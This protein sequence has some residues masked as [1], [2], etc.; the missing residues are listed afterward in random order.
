MLLFLQITGKISAAEIYFKKD[1]K[2]TIRHYNIVNPNYMFHSMINANF[3]QSEKSNL[4]LYKMQPSV[5]H[6]IDFFMQNYINVM[7]VFKGNSIW[8]VLM[9]INCL[10]NAKC[11]TLNVIKDDFFF[12]KKPMK[13]HNH[14][15]HV[16]RC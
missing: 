15:L 5:Y 2:I 1:N 6:C 3:N 8:Y 9:L 10:G 13:P 12:V 14:T 11:V 4:S 7:Q 16:R